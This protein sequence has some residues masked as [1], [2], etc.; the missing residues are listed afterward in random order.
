V[1]PFSVLAAMI[2]GLFDAKTRFTKK[3]GPLVKQKILLG[4]ILLL[5]SAASAVLINQESFDFVGKTF[6]ITMGVVIL[7]CSVLLGQKGV[8]LLEAK[9][10]DQKIS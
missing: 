10:V 5:S 3:F 2:A 8:M 9:T 6:V 7:A 4:I 1:L